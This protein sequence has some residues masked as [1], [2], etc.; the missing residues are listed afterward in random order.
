MY[1][2][3]PLKA[4]LLPFVFCC[5]LLWFKKNVLW[6]SDKGC[7]YL[8]SMI[9]GVNDEMG[10]IRDELQI[11]RYAVRDCKSRTG[12]WISNTTVNIYF[13]NLMKL[14]SINSFHVCSIVLQNDFSFTF[15]CRR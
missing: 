9:F 2:Y 4:L 6:S 13:F 3:L 7:A 1:S 15:E 5:Y 10:V 8:R 11:L 12:A 14:N